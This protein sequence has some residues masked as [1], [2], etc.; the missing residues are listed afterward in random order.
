MAQTIAEQASETQ[1]RSGV[2]MAVVVWI[3]TAVFYF[4]QYAMRSAPAVMMPQLSSAFNASALGVAS[5]VGIFYYGYSPF[6]LVA[7]AAMDRL[8]P[9][10]LVP[11]AA[12]GV[13]IGALLFA[14]GD[15]QIASIGRFLQGACGVFALVGA[16]YIATKNF[17]VS[18]AATLIGATQM[19]GMAGGAAGQFVVGPMIGAGLTWNYFWIGMGVIGLIIGVILFFLMPSERAAQ[20]TAGGL[21][22][23]AS[24]FATVFKNPQSILCGLIAGLLFIPTTIFDMIWGVRYLQEAHGF[25]YGSAVMRSATVPFGWIIGCPLLGLLSDRLGRRKPVIIGAA[26][27]LLAC[28][29]WILYGPTEVFPPYVL[30][31]V[32]G[33]AS[34]AAMLPYIVIKEA[35][36]PQFGGTATGVVNFL[37]FT[38]S[39]LLGPVFG[40]LLLRVSG[41]AERMELEHYQI[42]F[43]PLL[44]GVVI[45]I[46]LAILLKETGPAVRKATVG[47]TE[48]KLK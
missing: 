16:I 44:Y 43:K 23:V 34:G 39:A 38:F 32:A 22:V 9:R 35:N 5:I 6:S 42:A 14:T 45:A 4:Y 2:R 20:Q 31:L 40:W 48:E 17:P 1:T 27:V 36:P 21:K 15:T 18:E 28:L 13:G 10:L 37:N 47:R 11:F 33:L 30:G 41:G 12:A 46:I 8:G 24:A 7:G 29:G 25:E 19:F 3:L 26:I